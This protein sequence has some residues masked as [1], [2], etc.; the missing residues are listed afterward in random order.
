MPD[1]RVDARAMG[2]F[3]L[4]IR[5]AEQVSSRRTARHALAQVDMDILKRRCIL[6]VAIECVA[7]RFSGDNTRIS[8][9]GEAH[10]TK[11]WMREDGSFAGRLTERSASLGCGR[12]LVSV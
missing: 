7:R 5:P 3:Q 10:V 6:G 8:R 9:M 12:A 11:V 1:M 4:E 2:T